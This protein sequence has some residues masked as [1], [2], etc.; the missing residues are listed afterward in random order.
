MNENLFDHILFNPNS[1]K[2]ILI[3]PIKQF[4]IGK[5]MVG[6]PLTLKIMPQCIQ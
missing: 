6:S 2:R 4:N 5:L 1:N 3:K